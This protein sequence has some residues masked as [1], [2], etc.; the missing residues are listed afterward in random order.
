MEIEWN[1]CR[2]LVGQDFMF[3]ICKLRAH[4]VGRV[5]GA[6]GCKTGFAGLLPSKVVFHDAYTLLLQK[7]KFQSCGL[8][9]N[10]KLRANILKNYIIILVYLRAKEKN[11]ARRP[12]AIAKKNTKNFKSFTIGT[13]EDHKRANCSSSHSHPCFFIF[14]I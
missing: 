14:Y 9:K 6:S 8:K 1:R 12:I 2:Q 10:C 3:Q 13:L 11:S 7:L 4:G 5:G